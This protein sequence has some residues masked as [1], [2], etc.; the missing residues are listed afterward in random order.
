MFTIDQPKRDPFAPNAH[1]DLPD[2]QTV[3]E[4]AAMAIAG[5]VVH[6]GAKAAL[7]KAVARLKARFGDD[8]DV[9]DGDRNDD[10]N[11]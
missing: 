10:A 5:G 9:D 7:G 2:L 4:F 6:D 3:V 8:V 1:R 11:T